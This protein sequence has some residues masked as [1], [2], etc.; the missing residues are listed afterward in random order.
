MG[1]LVGFSFKL[2]HSIVEG[3]GKSLKKTGISGVPLCAFFFKYLSQLESRPVSAG[4][5]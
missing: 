5:S 1:E 2:S 3:K 4:G